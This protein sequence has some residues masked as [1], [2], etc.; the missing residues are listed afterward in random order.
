MS[1]KQRKVFIAEAVI[2]FVI[3]AAIL[4]SQLIGTVDVAQDLGELRTVDNLNGK[5]IGT[6]PDSEWTE[7]A[8]EMWP[9]SVF[10]EAGSV[11]DL[12]QLT[13]NRTIDAFL[14]S[15]SEVA[16]ILLAYPELTAMLRDISTLPDLKT[17]ECQDTYIENL[18]ISNNVYLRG[19]IFNTSAHYLPGVIYY[20]YGTDYLLKFDNDVTIYY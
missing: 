10:H 6:V 20:S 12:A 3:L 9:S 4:L 15:R 14:V 5:I 19:L 2:V 16:D 17:L 13:M 1:N 8:H 11:N 7:S 18:N